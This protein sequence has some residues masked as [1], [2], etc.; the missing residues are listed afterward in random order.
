MRLSAKFAGA[1]RQKI[2]RIWRMGKR[3]MSQ[4]LSFHP[5]NAREL[6]AQSI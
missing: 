2:V 4:T 5:A 6:Q 1:P 3:R